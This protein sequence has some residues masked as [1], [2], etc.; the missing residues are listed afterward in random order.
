MPLAPGD[1][2]GPYEILSALGSGSIGE[3]YKA[4]DTRLDR[5]VAIKVSNS[6]FS[7]RLEREA[8]AVTALHHPH[9]CQL[10]E[11]VTSRDAP[12][13]LVMEY[14]E[15]APLKAPL[16][17]DQA[18]KYAAQ[19][20]DALYAAH[21]QNITHGNLKPANILVTQAGVK[22]MDFGLADVEPAAGQDAG[23]RND[24]LALGLVL[25]ELL[26]DVAP[27]SLHRVLQRCLE[28]DPENRWHSARDLN[29]ALELVTHVER[30]F[31]LRHARGLLHTKLAWAVAA[32][33]TLA[34]AALAFVHFRQKPPVK[35]VLRFEIPP[36]T[37][38]VF[39]NNSALV[40]SPD[41]GKIAFIA[42]GADRKQMIWV[43]SL[44][45]EEARPLT[46]TE[47]TGSTL[48]WS[49]EGRYLAFQSGGTLK[50]IEATGGLAQTLCDAASVI[51]G[52]WT[53][54]NRILFGGSE[55]LQ[56]VSAAGGM[57]T[58]LTTV[59]HSRNELQHEGPAMLP[60]GHRFV[61][62]RVSLPLEDG[63]V[64]I[65]SLDAKPEQQSASRLLPDATRAVYV[66]SPLTGDSPGYLLFVRGVTVSSPDGTLM[67]RPF[68]PKRMEFTGRPGSG[69]AVPVAEQVYAFGGFSAS[70]AGVLAFGSFSTAGTQA[71]SQLTW[72]DRKGA[73][74]AT[75]GEAGEYGNL[76]LSPD[77][78]RVAYRRGD[79][80]WLFD[81]ARG[82][83]PARLTSGNPAGYP[84]WSPDGSRIVFMSTRG[85]AYGIYRKA[86]NLA[87]QEELL[88]Q[89]PN[90]KGVPD[91]TSDGRFVI[92]NTLSSDGKGSDLSVLP[93]EGSAADRNPLSFLRTD[94]NEHNGRFSPDG[95][96][97]AFSSNR[98]GKYEIYVLPFDE[99]N[100]GSSA[101]GA[102]H[103]VS[104][105]GG[106][107]AHWSGDGKELFY[108]A[109]DDYLM[110][111]AVSVEGSAFHTGTPQRL[112]KKPMGS[113]DVT[114]DG[115]RF[116]IAAP[117]APGSAAPASRPY[118]VVVNWTGL[119]KR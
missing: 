2:L 68:D 23:P 73:I 87:G 107:N 40:L 24:I 63:G 71:N 5:I 105:D 84:A 99:S 59:D 55:H 19:I 100:P 109:P 18:L 35:E 69:D 67:A 91:F 111:V 85:D 28:K 4:R 64:Y 26:A 114:A 86:S 37:N 43:R 81:F 45:T 57:P 79:D 104:K 15:G 12:N 83:A 116:L 117:P 6:P 10:Y 39:G 13:F 31:S 113:W 8:R 101:A 98:S 56:V 93:V 75:A 92:Y 51:G 80:L 41:G 49:P 65:G 72:Y 74:A 48:I 106:D 89:S 78:M 97:V 90:P 52:V 118:H 61:Y 94:F 47:G 20:C 25:H 22:L 7:E 14:I 119:L 88:F 30:A 108:M 42:T 1:K 62:S 21:K 77:E 32:A 50:R 115:Q 33:V 9:I 70:P 44:Y 38:A 76:A 103:Q 96:W 34:L 3:V 29:A 11:V 102:P 27:P 46:G 17:L 66:P 53:S 82:G 58:P 110:S 54:D 36:P 112:F 16:P 95:R 60:G